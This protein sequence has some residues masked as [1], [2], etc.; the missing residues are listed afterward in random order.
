M[1]GLEIGLRLKYSNSCNPLYYNW[2]M[3]IM[4]LDYGSKRVG[5][6]STDDSGEFALPRKVLPNDEALLERVMD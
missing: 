5:I 1:G 3:K 4:A 6:A 2:T